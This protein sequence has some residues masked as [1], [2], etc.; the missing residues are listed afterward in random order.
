MKKLIV[1]SKESGN[2]HKVCSYVSGN[3]DTDLKVVG[4]TTKYDL[5]YYDVI[6]LASGVYM[7]HV[8]ANILTWINSIE[9]NTIDSN[10]KFYLFL[11]WFGRGNSDKSAFDEVKQLLKAKGIELE[12]NYMKCFGKGMG[13]IRISHPNEEDCKN[14][15]LWTN[16][17]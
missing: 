2:T 11:T 15:L 16:K 17:L 3:S 1:Y 5:P 10:T 6:I 14:V 8:H 12:D 13:M 4:K 9:K 7:N